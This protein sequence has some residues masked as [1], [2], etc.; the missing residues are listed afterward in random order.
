MAKVP[1][2]PPLVCLPDQP[3]ANCASLNS[4]LCEAIKVI[5]SMKDSLNY[6]YD[7]LQDKNA[8]LSRCKASSEEL[9]KTVAHVSTKLDE[10]TIEITRLK[11]KCQS[12]RDNLLIDGIPEEKNEEP[13][14]RA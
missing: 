11:N 6:M 10:Q 2:I 4:K 3:K 13:K 7:M 9:V 5:N 8:E 14:P 12:R 1:A